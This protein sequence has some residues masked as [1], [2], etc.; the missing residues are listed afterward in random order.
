MNELSSARSPVYCRS[1]ILDSEIAT[2]NI[3]N[4][5]LS[6]SSSDSGSKSLGEFQYIYFENL[7]SSSEE[8]SR[9]DPSLA[10]FKEQLIIWYLKYNITTVALSDLL[11]ILREFDMFNGLPKN[12]RTFL[13]NKSDILI[14]NLD[15]GKFC[16][17][18]L[19][20]IFSASWRRFQ[21][22]NFWKIH[23]EIIALC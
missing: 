10:F 4:S 5:N 15:E 12:G 1:K 6:S 7:N 16:Y 11:K 20:K 17:F 19:Q 3:A 23:L 8:S 22:L 14:R 21:I 18:E 9:A 2:T 13:K